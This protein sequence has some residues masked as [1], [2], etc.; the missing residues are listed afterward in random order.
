[1]Q[2]VHVRAPP[3]PRQKGCRDFTELEIAVVRTCS[4]FEFTFSVNGQQVRC[5]GGPG[6]PTAL[7]IPV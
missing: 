4:Q 6:A 5:H 2:H 7:L 1:M 3:P